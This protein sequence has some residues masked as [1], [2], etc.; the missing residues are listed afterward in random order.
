MNE[1]PTYKTGQPM[2]ISPK[3][4]ALARTLNASIS[5]SVEVQLN[6]ATTFIRC[7]AVA[8]DVYLRWGIEDANGST[9]D[10]IIPAGQ[11]VD[12]AI[13]V[14]SAGARF[15]YFNVVERVSGATFI[16]IEK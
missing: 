7:Y 5:T 13:P 14:D 16:A 2:Q 3:G 9:F 12:L 1:Q 4:V 8:Q 11:I 15:N 6:A 10:E